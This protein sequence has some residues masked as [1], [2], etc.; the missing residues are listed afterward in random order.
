MHASWRECRQAD[1]DILGPGCVGRAVLN[2]FSLVRDHGLTGTHI[3]GATLVRHAQHALQN[4]GELIKLGRLPRLHPAG[5]AAHVRDADGAMPAIDP[6]D[7][8]VDQ[9][10]LVPRRLDACRRGDQRRHVIL[11]KATIK[12]LATIQV[13][14]DGNFTVKT[15]PIPRLDRH[16]CYVPFLSA[17]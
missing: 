1:G 12:S 15:D 16:P 5:G 7:E 3:H 13:T 2:P 17:R 14:Y 10:G 8:L 9:L 11:H 6:A 4:D